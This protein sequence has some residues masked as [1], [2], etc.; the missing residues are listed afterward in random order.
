VTEWRV[1]GDSG[2]EKTHCFC[3]ICGAPVYLLLDVM[4]DGIAVH[5]AS[6]DNPSMFNP[7]VVTYAS[8]GSDWDKM[9][10]ELPAF[11]TMPPA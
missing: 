1:A 9:D 8:T 7:A 6:L 2:K 5:A 3:A 10:A 4:P 11:E